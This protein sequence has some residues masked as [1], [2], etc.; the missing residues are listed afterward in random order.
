[1]R[2]MVSLGWLVGAL[3]PVRLIGLYEG[4]GFTGLVG[5]LSPVNHIG[6]YEG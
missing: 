1:M 5:A 4:Y 6:L 3:S 2:A